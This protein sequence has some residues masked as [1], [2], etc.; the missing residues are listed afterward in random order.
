MLELDLDVVLPA[1]E[2]DGRR[3]ED[4][5]SYPAVVPGHRRRRRR[6][7]RG[8]D[9]GRQRARRP[10][11]R[12]CATCR[13]STSTAGEQVGEGRKS[14]ALRLEFRSEERTLTDEEVADRREQIKEALAQETGGTLRE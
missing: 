5:I 3:Y 10:A 2:R 8:P 6:G 7:G 13:C 9:G 1:A 11:G 12:S 4:L 14:L